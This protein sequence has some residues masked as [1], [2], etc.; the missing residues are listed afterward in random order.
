MIVSAAASKVSSP[1]PQVAPPSRAAPLAASPAPTKDPFAPSKY[2]QFE[3]QVTNGKC[4]VVFRHAAG[5]VNKLFTVN[6]CIGDTPGVSCVGPTRRVG[7]LALPAV[8]PDGDEFHV[9]EIAAARGGNATPSVEYWVAVVKTDAVWATARPF[10]GELT[11]AMLVTAKPAALVLE[12][13]PTT[14][15]TGARYTATFGKVED[16]KLPML[17]STAPR[18]SREREIE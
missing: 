7:T 15:D 3:M 9:F 1:P 13:S 17:P 10:E 12:Q 14:T 4:A 5:T 2:G 8:A 11:R 6:D 18:R 16:K